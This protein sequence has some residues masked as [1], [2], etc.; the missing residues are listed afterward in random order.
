V[1][2]VAEAGVTGFEANSW[3]SLVAPRATPRAIVDRLN[4]AT[5]V[6]LNDGEIR[7]RLIQQGID[8]DPGTPE[9]LT[10]YVKV[11]RVRFTKLP[12]VVGIKPE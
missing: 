9:E 4:R 7:D 11:E 1:P 5:A 2:T 3:N 12:E 6:I 10:P 8:V